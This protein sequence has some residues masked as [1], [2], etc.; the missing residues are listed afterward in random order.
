MHSHA[1]KRA[2]SRGG[3][4]AG[5]GV[6][7]APSP[8]PSPRVA[9]TV[10]T[11]DAWLEAEA[12]R[13]VRAA[14][15]GP[16]GD[17]VVPTF[18][19]TTPAAA[20]VG[21]GDA[22]PSAL[23][24]RLESAYHADLGAVRLHTDAGA[25]RLAHHAGARAFAAGRHVVVGAGEPTAPDYDD[26][27]AH[28]IAHVLQQVGRRA[29]DGRLR[30]A[31]V[32]GAGAIQCAPLTLPETTTI[33]TIAEIGAR[34]VAADTP[35]EPGVQAFVGDIEQAIAARGEA[36]VLGELEREATGAATPLA[37]PAVTTLNW[38]H[39]SYVID[40]LKRAGSHAAA[41]ALF[42]GQPRRTTFL[43]N[44]F[45]QHI[46]TTSPATLAPVTRWT[47]AGAAPGAPPAT[48]LHLFSTMGLAAF[49]FTAAEYL[50]GVTRPIQ[51]VG[52][53]TA[54]LV[55]ALAAIAAPSAVLTIPGEAGPEVA[56]ERQYAVIEAVK[57]LHEFQSGKLAELA[58]AVTTPGTDPR[59]LTP[60][61]RRDVAKRLGEWAT[62]AAAD[63]SQLP[64]SMPDEVR[65]LVTVLLPAYGTIA[66]HAQVTLDSVLGPADRPAAEQLAVRRRALHAGASETEFTTFRT[67][68]TP[69]FVALLA[70]DSDGNIPSQRVFSAAHRT[71][72]DGLMRELQ[73]HFEVRGFTL[74]RGAVE[75][76]ARGARARGSNG[77]AHLA[78]AA[79]LTELHELLGRYDAA[80]DQTREDELTPYLGP[81]DPAGPMPQ[82]GVPD[83]R[84]RHRLA[85]ARWLAAT[86]DALGWRDLARLGRVVSE[87]RQVLP[88]GT[89]Q[90]HSYVALFGSWRASDD[91]RINR[92]T[93]DF[94]PDAM[95]TSNRPLTARH[96]RDFFQL[97][98]YQDLAARVRRILGSDRAAGAVGETAILS[99][100]L[101]ESRS[102]FV[103][104][105]RYEHEGDVAT[106]LRPGDEGR[107]GALVIAHPLTRQFI[108]DGAKR[109]V[110]P[111][112]LTPNRPAA[113]PYFWLVPSIELLV[114]RLRV[115][116]LDD[117]VLALLTAERAA[118]PGA[119]EPEAPPAAELTS[120]TV[121]DLDWSA[122]LL[123]LSRAITS[124]R[125]LTPAAQAAI[126]GL[127]P[128]LASDRDVQFQ[129]FE[130]AARAATSYDRVGRVGHVILPL[131][132]QYDRYDELSQV[133]L[134]V[135]GAPP[136]TGL[137]WEIPEL[138]VDEI[139]RFM[140]VV[141]PAAEQ[142]AQVSAMLLE[143][144]EQLSRLLGVA[145]GDPLTSVPSIRF[146]I[147][148]ALFP[149]VDQVVRFVR[150]RDSSDAGRLRRTQ[151]AAVLPR[152]EPWIEPRVARLE[153]IQ[154][155]LT[156]MLVTGQDRFGFR[157]V[158]VNA[159]AASRE[160]FFESVGPGA[161][162]MLG[163]AFTIDGVRY[164]VRELEHNLEYHE[165]YGV[166]A[167]RL[168]SRL[169]VDGRALS[170]ADRASDRTPLFAIEL[171]TASNVRTITANQADDA[172]LDTISRATQMFGLVESMRELGEALET[173]SM[174]MI[175]AAE[176]IPGAGQAVMVAR[177]AMFVTQF[178][179]SGE[180]DQLIALV[181]NDPRTILEGVQT[182]LAGLVRPEVLL[183]FFLFGVNHFDALGRSTGA[184]PSSRP[185][186]RQ[187]GGRGR[188]GRVVRR[189][190][191]FGRNVLA[192][193]GR[194]QARVRQRAERTQMYL[195]GKP[196]VPRVLRFAADHLP[197]M[198]L[199]GARLADF[200]DN[201]SNAEA[202]IRTAMADV[203][204]TLS[205]FLDELETVRLP[206]NLIDP[207]DILHIVVDLV[208]RRLG[209]KYR[210]AIGLM[211][212]LLDRVG[213]RHE[214]EVAIA[215]K[216]VGAWDP[217]E[218][219]RGIFG[220]PDGEG[221]VNDGPLVTPLKSVRDDIVG[222]VL[223]AIGSI[224]FLPAD[225][226][227]A[228]S[229]EATGM[230]AR[231]FSIQ[232]D[233]EGFEGES[234]EVEGYD[235]HPPDLTV[236]IA[237]APGFGTGAPLPPASRRAAE[238]R[239]GHD[240][241]H[242]RVHDD[243]DGAR[244]TRRF[245]A[246]ALTSGSHVFVRPGLALG[247]GHGRDVLNHEL[248]HVLQQTGP[249]VLGGGHDP[250]A[251][252]GTPGRGLRIDPA[253][254]V[255]ADRIS[256]SLRDHVATRP[257][258]VGAP[259]AHGLQ[260]TF[261]EAWI[262][263]VTDLMTSSAVAA[264]AASPAAGSTASHLPSELRGQVSNVA[265]DLRARFNAAPNASDG[266]TYAS[267]WHHATPAAQL[268]AYV[269]D[270]TRWALISDA[271]E[272]LARNASRPRS[273]P[274]SGAPATATT[275]APLEL[276][277]AD[278]E[279]QLSRHIL[280]VTGIL[281]HIDFPRPHQAPPAPLRMGVVRVITIHLPI[282]SS[283]STLFRQAFD[284]VFTALSGR[285]A[286][287][288]RE[289]VMRWTQ[290]YLEGVRGL[291]ASNWTTAST[292]PHYRLTDSVLSAIEALIRANAGGA[293]PLTA[294]S[295]PPAA[296]YADTS[297]RGT[298][299][300]G[301]VG[302]R[303]GVFG[304]STQ[305]GPERE[306]HHVTQFV[307]LEF[308]ANLHSSVRAFPHA[309]QPALYGG[310]GT[311]DA[312]ATTGSGTPPHVT[313]F[314][315][316]GMPTTVAGTSASQR[317]P[318]MPAV[319]LA[320]ET[321]RNAR[322]HIHNA[323]DE[324]FGA[325]VA[326]TGSADILRAWYHQELRARL[327]GH[328]GSGGDFVAAEA[329][330]PA[331][332]QAYVTSTP[333]TVPDPRA[334][335]ATAIGAS[336]KAT[337]AR[338]RDF[339]Q[340]R[341]RIGLYT[342]ERQYYQTVAAQ[343]GHASSSAHHLTPLQVSRVFS[344]AVARNRTVFEADNHWQ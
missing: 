98:Y 84:V 124:G 214:I 141:S 25:A 41:F 159:T 113:T 301:Q 171:G 247:G 272:A 16:R 308:F 37:R 255:A 304:D 78:M 244:L 143:L 230:A 186:M 42:A 328:A 46:A 75:R 72:R 173:F 278:F 222:G 167:A 294:A 248:T 239:F 24:A 275:T 185:L 295:L 166:G 91:Q 280:D 74:W 212:T 298:I 57:R 39:K 183:E 11:R 6:R 136:R 88:D 338:L 245:G 246:Q 145:P 326:A 104:P 206:Y 332:M 306:S 61:Q 238:A 237:A 49:A 128:G 243:A 176:F 142:T 163:T 130:R 138:V 94:A 1:G 117:V 164:R 99:R 202:T 151:L 229:A 292:A 122:W 157:G 111:F 137:I 250:R 240:F 178:I 83:H 337:Y 180:M 287:V 144:A 62:A 96:L 100:A 86:A 102:Q 105:R 217:N 305:R 134:D 80:A 321:H 198:A 147:V 322:L 56:D 58:H 208:V 59:T 252:A 195:L 170:W 115:P 121:R 324:F 108:A 279:A 139:D 76:A 27:L 263:R 2:T 226:Q 320:A 14:R 77:A 165:A 133:S 193:F 52:G 341:L 109:T 9:R 125:A 274:A 29:G 269:L 232:F 51:A 15:G 283:N 93:D 4:A 152:G 154:A 153:A 87:S 235:A 31:D 160:N 203:P 216:L 223:G 35:V 199:M 129:A 330:G 26:L 256:T 65:A 291:E 225:L 64:T 18:H 312:L 103:G 12:D 254:E 169:I 261:G 340:P 127:G 284:P 251:I 288:S 318:G 45:Y 90:A 204:G 210:I 333:P 342:V 209:G 196:Y 116:V 97:L 191:N 55:A 118:Q 344:A 224:P 258:D 343:A 228:F 177:L 70:L 114:G 30:V 123:A 302:L 268:K 36:T 162:V 119:A 34:H 13:A 38:R 281:V 67:T 149:V 92:L 146:R 317:G 81:V 262:Q 266:V 19:G 319:L 112:D 260:P 182:A 331:A 63:A 205:H 241:A 131:I 249:R 85:V 310:T 156:Q 43:S 155:A 181:R 172:L 161:R 311:A 10:P 5:R 126:D 200:V 69:R 323:P 325:P 60:T 95:F 315:D 40:L 303:V 201:A 32:S 314:G 242:V 264:H 148:A 53:G 327:P 150:G 316:V 259:G 82:A 89:S 253:R 233:R 297:A 307:L 73:L 296:E 68:Y 107:Y 271:V 168:N 231:P 158:K 289:R 20:P 22:L 267:P 47:S 192:M 290:S 21:G 285:I 207:A 282:I 8:S 140:G 234:D 221:R 273:A 211:L 179:A 197:H 194:V 219:Y 187:T 33:P 300:G 339:M 313:A 120:A 309:S 184:D 79:R 106:A 189:L 257:V 175:D 17:G 270:S 28:E 135:S 220:A 215:N 44:A 54:P 48:P 213:L 236:P 336:M 265:T 71:L 7:G 101:V 66:R 23:S 335:V 3:R 190:W 329:S 188:L 299:Q 174:L 132:A 227:A 276:D 218:F 50:L 286:G 277:V 293:S 110:R 334:R